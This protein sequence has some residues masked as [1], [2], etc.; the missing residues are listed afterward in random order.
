MPVLAYE[1]IRPRLGERVYVALGIPA[2][3]V[4]LLDDREL[5]ANAEISRRYLGIKEAWAA[6]T[7]Y[8]TDEGR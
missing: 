4:R 1:R 6:E 2:R 8:G 5:E 7:G 3:V